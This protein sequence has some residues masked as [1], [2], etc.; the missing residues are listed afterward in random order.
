MILQYFRP[1]NCAPILTVMFEQ[2]V[3]NRLPEHLLW[4][5]LVLKSQQGF[6]NM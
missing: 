5:N 6:L 1:I 2:L 3:K 4:H